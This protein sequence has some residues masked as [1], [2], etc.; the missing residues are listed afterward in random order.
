MKPRRITSILALLMLCYLALPLTGLILQI[1]PSDLANV[2]NNSQ[3]WEAFKLSI[4]T[5]AV[6]TLIIVLFGSA[7]AWRIAEQHKRPS[8]LTQALIQWPIIVPPSVLGIALLDSFGRQGILGNLTGQSIAF[9]TA[10]VVVVQVLVAAPLY[11]QTVLASFQGASHQ[12]IEVGR[13]MGASPFLLLR[14]VILPLHKHAILGGA[15]LASA[16]ALGEFG[17]TLIFA[18]NLSGTTQTVPLAIYEMLETDLNTARMLA[19]LLLVTGSAL[20]AV[21][22]YAGNRGKP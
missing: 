3:I 21:T 13:T 10:A 2:T 15:A 20:V 9:T 18:G 19:L 4:L 11:V 7:L 14:H 8:I 6:S 17:A 5:T 12:L 1:T 16:R 22:F